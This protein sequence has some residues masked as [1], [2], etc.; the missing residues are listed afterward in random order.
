[1]SSR[2]PQPDFKAEFQQNMTQLD[3]I[4]TYIERI[5][6]LGQPIPKDL[7]EYEI[8]FRKNDLAERKAKLAENIERENQQL[9]K[10]EQ[11][12]E[13]FIKEAGL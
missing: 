9:L 4:K 2:Q 5:K 1:M 7:I 3:S 12:N 11:S 13:N 6:A 8:N 10:I